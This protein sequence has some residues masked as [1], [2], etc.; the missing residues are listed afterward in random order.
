VPVLSSLTTAAPAETLPEPLSPLAQTETERLAALEDVIELGFQSFIE[1][2]AALFEIRS[3]RLYRE[4]H[5]TFEDYLHD[6]WNMSRQR[7]HQLIEAAEVAVNLSTVVDTPPTSERQLR[8]L[9]GLEP[10]RQRAVWTAATKHNPDPTAQQVKNAVVE[11]AEP[12]IEAKPQLRFLEPHLPEDPAAAEAVSVRTL[13]EA[14]VGVVQRLATEVPETKEGAS[15]TPAGSPLEADSVEPASPHWKGPSP[16]QATH[17]STRPS[18][19]DSE[20][21][22]LYQRLVG[23]IDSVVASAAELEIRHLKDLCAYMR[24]KSKWLSKTEK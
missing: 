12:V 10:D 11:A 16:V 3:T 13:L 1:V 24:D 2:G 7:A 18:F 21:F 8:P 6:R 17:K 5:R 9:A 4:T 22:K 15:E 23:R 19:M 14:D 20:S